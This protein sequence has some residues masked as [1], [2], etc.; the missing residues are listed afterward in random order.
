MSVEAGK[1]DRAAVSTLLAVKVWLPAPRA[2]VLRSTLQSS[3]SKTAELT[4]TPP[5]IW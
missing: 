2:E 5:L 3:G 4:V 1:A